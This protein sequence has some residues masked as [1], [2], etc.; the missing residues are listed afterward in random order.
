MSP[1]RCEACPSVP[2]GSTGATVNG[3]QQRSRIDCTRAVSA[4]RS[5][6]DA[7][8]PE[9]A[10]ARIRTQIVCGRPR[11]GIDPNLRLLRPTRPAVHCLSYRLALQCG[12][13]KNLFQKA[14][15]CSRQI[16]NQQRRCTSHT[17]TTTCFVDTLDRWPGDRKSY[18]I[19]ER[20]YWLLSTGTNPAALF[21]VS[22]T[23]ASA[24]DLRA[25]MQRYCA[26]KGR[27]SRQ[28]RER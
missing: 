27:G 26:Q 24:R 4:Q 11:L 25:R 15:L 9:E 16:A 2:P 19:E 6:K 12:W 22:F 7:F 5:A 28:R 18:A 8:E 23:R 13:K 14:P 20:V 3:S 10:V 1:R 17:C 21:V